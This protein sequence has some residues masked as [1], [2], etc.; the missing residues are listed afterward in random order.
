MDPLIDVNEEKLQ[1][2]KNG[3]TPFYEE[4]LDEILREITKKVGGDIYLSGIDGKNYLDLNKFSDIKVE[5]LNF[6]HPKYP[7]RF[8]EFIPYL[9][10][11]DLLFNCGQDSIE[12]ITKSV[13]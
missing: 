2:T 6:E 13:C 11:I 1:A 4:G 12:L 5:F 8:D 7:Q 3:M 10:I 9:S